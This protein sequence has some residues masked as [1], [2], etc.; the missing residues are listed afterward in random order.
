M[1]TFAPEFAIALTLS[2]LLVPA[3]R[4]ASH[5]FGRV[6]QPREDRWHRRPVALFGGVGIGLAL[7]GTA[8]GFGLHRDMT[9]ML[10]CAAVVFVVGLVDDFISLKPATKLIVQ[11]AVAAAHLLAEPP[12]DN[13]F[14]WDACKRVVG[15]HLTAHDQDGVG[16][17]V[18]EGFSSAVEYLQ[19]VEIALGNEP[20]EYRPISSESVY[21]LSR[22]EVG[23]GRISGDGSTGAWAAWDN[24]R[25][26]R[27][28]AS[29]RRTGSVPRTSSP[30][31]GSKLHWPSTTLRAAAGGAAARRRIAWMRSTSSCGS[32][33]LAR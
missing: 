16:C 30:R 33:G 7:F 31:P 24:W 1:L 32:K 23:G 11:I 20:E 6:A 26:R 5:R 27:V 17:C 12:P 15:G 19:C 14:L 9:V 13:V 10:G 2:L 3:C 8:V 21:G 22:V 25:R 28:S 18:G 29:V 4:F